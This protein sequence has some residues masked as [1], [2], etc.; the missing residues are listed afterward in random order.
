MIWGQIA[1]T[2]FDPQALCHGLDKMTVLVAIASG[3]RLVGTLGYKLQ[4]NREAHIRGMAVRPEWHG[5][6]WPG[7]CCPVWSR[8][9]VLLV[10]APREES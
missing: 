2:V 9:F 8:T 6:P 10:V 3:N 7:A 5:R 1:D 4:H